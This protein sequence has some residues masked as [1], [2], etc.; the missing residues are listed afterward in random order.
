MKDSY[1]V[2]RCHHCTARYLTPQPDDSTLAS[3]YS[4]NYFLHDSNPESIDQITLLKHQTANIYLDR[5]CKVN[6]RSGGRL[7][8]IGCGTGAFL[9]EARKRKFDITGIEYSRH[10]VDMGNKMLGGSYIYAGDIDSVDLPR[11]HFDFVVMA[12][13][14]EHVRAPDTF[15]KKVYQLLT[16]NGSVF[17]AT[18]SLDSV[19]AKL[20]GR[21]WMEYKI[22]HL[23][24]FN[25][26][27]VSA[28]LSKCGFN[29]I[30][31]YPNPKS[32]SIDYI[33]R[34]FQRFPVPVISTLIKLAVKIIPKLILH[35]SLS[36]D[37][38]GMIVI[39]NK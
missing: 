9:S 7:L 32:L 8:E 36:L 38:G 37:A 5:L 4:E 25:K 11:G 18:P 26:R 39:A 29:D 28:L 16:P 15:I 24:Y 22:E 23:F 13:V 31:I 20:L 30:R 2:A 3:I 35:R 33:N 12:D 21:Y 34:H 19:L 10:A 27:S 1:W 14:I 6:K 17:I